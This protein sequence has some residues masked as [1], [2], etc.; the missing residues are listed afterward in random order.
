[1]FSCKILTSA[2][3]VC[4]SM[5][6]ISQVLIVETPIF[7]RQI[8]AAMSDEMYRELQAALIARPDMG[9]VIPRS[10]GLR[11]VR[12]RASGHGKRGGVRI[13]YYWAVTREIILMLF[14]Y[15]K[16]VQD[17]LTSQQLRILRALVEE[18]YP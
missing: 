9:P 10:G 17:D 11:K 7:T 1:M 4:T 16:N 6:H 18:E 12:W 13:I 3:D 15:P 5:A 14:V 2:I 8:Q